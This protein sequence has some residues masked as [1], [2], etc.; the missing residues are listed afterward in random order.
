MNENTNTEANGTPQQ[1]IPE[2]Q[3]SSQ[4]PSYPVPPAP[5][6]AQVPVPYY[7][8]PPNPMAKSPAVAV[9]L[10]LVLTF[11]HL[12]LGLYQRA[13]MVF[14]AFFLTIIMVPQTPIKVFICIF[15]WFFS[16]FDAYRQAQIINLGEAEEPTKKTEPRGALFFGIFMIAAGSLLLVNNF[17]PIDFDWLQQWWPVLVIGIGVWVI[18]SWLREKSAGEESGDEE[19]GLEREY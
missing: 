16:I 2:P 8:Q 6:P 11:G 14:T 10:S 15:I 1:E 9:L 19:S 17:Y 13:V 5:A 3:S 18:F 4:E 12:Y 7:S